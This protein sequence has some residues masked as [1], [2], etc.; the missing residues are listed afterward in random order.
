MQAEL[1]HQLG[2]SKH[3]TAPPEQ[4]NRRNGA[5]FK[6]VKSSAGELAIEVPRDRAGDYEPICVLRTKL[7][8]DFAP[9]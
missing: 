9:I 8:T 4:P 5:S 3:E 1:T 2:Y 6:K 7:N